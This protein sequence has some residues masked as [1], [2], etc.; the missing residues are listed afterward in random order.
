ML[1]YGNRKYSDDLWEGAARTAQRARSVTGGA[2]LEC[3]R[4]SHLR[5]PDGAGD[6]STYVDHVVQAFG[7][8]GHTAL[9]VGGTR[10]E[11]VAVIRVG[12]AQCQS[13]DYCNIP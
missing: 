4:R 5:Q 8:S 10:R 2:R 1:M 6:T 13:L 9:H 7:R 11:T 3:R 12:V